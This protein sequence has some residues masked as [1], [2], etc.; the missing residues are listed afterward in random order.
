MTDYVKVQGHNGLVRDMNSSAIINKDTSAYERAVKR[1]K[2]A[3]AKRD[4]LRSATR[5]INNLKCEMHEIK[6]MLKTLVDRNGDNSNNS[7]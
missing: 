6:T 5:E 1:A 7:R 3:Q 2:E 4:E